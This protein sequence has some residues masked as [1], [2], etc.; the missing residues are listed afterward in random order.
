LARDDKFE[1]LIFSI[2][3]TIRLNIKAFCTRRDRWETHALGPMVTVG[4]LELCTR[5][6]KAPPIRNWQTQNC[7][8][9]SYEVY[10]LDGYKRPLCSTGLYLGWKRLSIR[11]CHHGPSGFRLGKGPRPQERPRL[12]DIHQWRQLLGKERNTT[13]Y[14][15]IGHRGGVGSRHGMRTGY[16]IC[17]KNTVE[18]GTFGAIATDFGDR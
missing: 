15:F 12:E 3:S 2:P 4:Q 17:A 14:N 16:V 1:C 5:F 10:G 18:F 6:N 8:A 7:D 11:I 9:S 13:K